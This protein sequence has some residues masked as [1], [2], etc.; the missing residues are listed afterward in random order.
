MGQDRVTAEARHGPEGV[1]LPLLLGERTRKG[2]RH[3]VAVGSG[4]LRGR[5]HQD[6]VAPPAVL[7]GEDVVVGDHDELQSRLPGGAHDLV[8][9]ASPVAAVGVDVPGAAHL[10]RDGG[11]TGSAPRPGV[12]PERHPGDEQ[13]AE[14]RGGPPGGHPAGASAD[15]PPS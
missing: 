6:A 11:G 10:A 9:A 4:D 1:P 12:E 2:R 13:R 8:E 7:R 15:A 5:D 14:H 3:D